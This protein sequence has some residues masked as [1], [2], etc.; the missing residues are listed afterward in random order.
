MGRVRQS[1]VQ[2]QVVNAVVV[3]PAAPVQIP[4]LGSDAMLALSLLLAL[5]GAGCMRRRR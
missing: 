1:L 4:T 5:L 3:T 2:N